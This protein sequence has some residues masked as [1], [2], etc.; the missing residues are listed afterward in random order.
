MIFRN[1]FVF[2]IYYQIAACY[3][4]KITT[5]NRIINCHENVDFV[6]DYVNRPTTNIGL[7]VIQPYYFS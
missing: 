1:F 3:P 7:L 2:F 6:Y 4:I 5:G